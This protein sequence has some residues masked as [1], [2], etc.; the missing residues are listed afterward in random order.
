MLGNIHNNYKSRASF[1]LQTVVGHGPLVHLD[2]SYGTLPKQRCNE[3]SK[4]GLVIVVVI[5]MSANPSK[6]QNIRH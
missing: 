6:Y 5:T 3:Y 1:F 2:Q 4:L